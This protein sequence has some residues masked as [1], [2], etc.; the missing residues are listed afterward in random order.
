MHADE[1][2]EVQVI[3]GTVKIL[4]VDDDQMIHDTMALLLGNTEF[5]LVSAMNVKGAIDIVASDRPDIIITDAMMPGESGFSL[6]D[7]LKSRPE[8]SR[9]PVILWTGLEDLSGG[10]KDSSRKADFTMSKPFYRSE[11]MAT[12]E[13]AKM[14]II[15]DKTNGDFST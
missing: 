5:S 15:S 4:L 3:P 6:I 7:K 1:E 9:I 2:D 10:A 14:S 12:L 11:I 13:R 8:T